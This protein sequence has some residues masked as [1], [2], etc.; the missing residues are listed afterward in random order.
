MNIYYLPE[1]TQWIID[2]NFKKVEKEFNRYFHI[3]LVHWP[4]YLSVKVFPTEIK[5][6]IKN[7][8]ESFIETLPKG[9]DRMTNLINY[10]NSEDQSQRLPQTKEYI[11]TLDKIRKTN[12]RSTFKELNGLLEWK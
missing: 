6:I 3:G 4:E 2:Q 1:F 7:K 5:E 11:D 9:F 10:M 8:L 12:F